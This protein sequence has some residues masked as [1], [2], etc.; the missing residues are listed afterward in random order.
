M[1]KKFRCVY[2]KLLEKLTERGI[3]Y[4]DLAQIADVSQMGVYRRITGATAWKLPEVV[5][6]CQFL[7]ESDAEKLFQRN[8]IPTDSL[9][10]DTIS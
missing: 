9:Q 10:F 5:A 7:G 6:V 1:A 8:N 2:P 4:R 3:S